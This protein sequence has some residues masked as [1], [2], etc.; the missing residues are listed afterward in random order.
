MGKNKRAREDFEPT[1]EALSGAP[2]KKAAS[3][4]ATTSAVEISAAQ[5]QRIKEARELVKKRDAARAAGDF[6]EADNIRDSLNGL[7]VS[8]VDQKG[9]PSGFRFADGSAHKL[10]AGYSGS[11]TTGGSQ[12]QALK[13][14]P[15]PRSQPKSESPA[16]P[17]KTVT[18][19]SE[20]PEQQRNRAV[21]DAVL[22]VNNG[23]GTRNVQ[24]MLVTDSVVG[25]GAVASRGS[26][27]KVHYVGKLKSN[28]RVFDK[29]KKPFS[30]TIGRG[31]VIRGWDLG[32]DGMKIG[33][34]RNLIIPATLAYGKTGAPPTIPPNSTLVFDVALIEVR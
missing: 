13:A 26:R 14:A 29:S 20:G 18:K 8:L 19:P 21:L 33:G 3:V 4:N 9:G 7:G 6:D 30:F 15:A 23:S 12:N 11:A 10:P 22:G 2:Q 17:K 24:G 28:G 32:V 5:I 31:E 34:K 25:T 1:E 27:V 16:Q